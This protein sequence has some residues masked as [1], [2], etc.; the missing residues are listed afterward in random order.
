MANSVDL[1]QTALGPRCSLL[2]LK[3]SVM[4]G[5]CFKCNRRLKQTPFSDAPFLGALRVK[6]KLIH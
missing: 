1:N 6:S 3:S 2:Y 4:L 5:N